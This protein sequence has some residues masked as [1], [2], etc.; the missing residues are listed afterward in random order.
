MIFGADSK[1]TVH[2]YLNAAYGGYTSSTPNPFDDPSW[3]YLTTPYAN[4]PLVALSSTTL[5]GAEMFDTQ[6]GKKVVMRRIVFNSDFTTFSYPDGG[7]LFLDSSYAL[8]SQTRPYLPVDKQ[9]NTSST[10]LYVYEDPFT[11]ASL[12]VVCE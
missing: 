2:A 4:M 1:L 6:Y 5:I 10:S 8:Y 9:Y 3:P 11:Y 12:N 7:A